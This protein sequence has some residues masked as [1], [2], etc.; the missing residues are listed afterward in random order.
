VRY[1]AG[2]W[3]DLRAAISLDKKARGR[4]VRF[5]LLRGLAAPSIV[6][7]PPEV[8]LAD[9]YRSIAPTL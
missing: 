4:S 2:A 8:T 3:P 6:A 7:D 9:A 5:V 1:P